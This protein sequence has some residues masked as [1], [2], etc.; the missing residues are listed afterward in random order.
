MA[1]IQ[2]TDQ[3]FKEVTIDSGKTVVVD[4]YSPDCFACEMLEPVFER[5]S[6]DLPEVVFASVNATL[7]PEIVSEF[8][9]MYA[10]TLLLFKN[11]ELVKKATGSLS[12]V[13]LEQFI[14]G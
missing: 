10:P 9:I 12:P 6:E 11:G 4:I 5:G 1:V 7:C 2:L 8:K 13:E 3:N 14:V